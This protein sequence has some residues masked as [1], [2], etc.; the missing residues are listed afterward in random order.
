MNEWTATLK[1]NLSDFKSP[2]PMAP[3]LHANVFTSTAW[4]LTVMGMSWVWCFLGRKFMAVLVYFIWIIFSQRPLPRMASFIL[5]T[6]P[7]SWTSLGK[8]LQV[9]FLCQRTE[10]DLKSALPLAICVTLGELLYTLESQFFHLPYGEGR[11]REGRRFLY[12]F[13]LSHVRLLV[14]TK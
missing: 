4:V 8:H 11:G 7:H 3:H 5:W 13:C 14:R 10:L 12:C 1:F 9:C 2:E 6:P